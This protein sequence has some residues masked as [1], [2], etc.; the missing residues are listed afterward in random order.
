V[1]EGAEGAATMAGVT[2]AGVT[3]AGATGAGATG[4]G[5]GTVEVLGDVEG[6]ESGRVN[7]MLRATYFLVTRLWL[8]KL[9]L[10]PL[11]LERNCLLERGGNGPQTNFRE[12]THGKTN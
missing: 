4:A 1:K 3:G 10:N 6:T 12:A 11:F 5:A 8:S 7:H 2:G 9:L